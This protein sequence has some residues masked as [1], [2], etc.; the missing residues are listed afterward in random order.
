VSKLK[1][2]AAV[3]IVAC[4]ALAV[5]ACGS[6]SNSGGGGETG[7]SSN[8]ESGGGESTTASSGG[9][10]EG[11]GGGELPSTVKVGF[12]DSM[13]GPA[14]FCGQEEKEGAELAIEMA[15]EEGL[16]G[17][18]KIQM[19]VKDD[20]AE[21]ES[22]VSGMNSLIGDSSVAATV[23]PCVG[24]IGQAVVP[25]AEQGEMPLV[26]TTA[27]GASV[28]G[29]WAFRAGLP[30][31]TYAA[32]VIPVIAEQA[33]TAGVIWEKSDA[34][35]AKPVWEE[36]QKPALEEN[37]VELV[38]DEPTGEQTSYTSQ[39]SAILSKHP[40]AVGVLVLG[41]P[42]LTIVKELRE[43]GFKGPIWGQLGMAA[44]FYLEGGPDTNGTF[45]AVSYAP[46]FKFP[47]SVKFTKGFE[48]KFHKTPRE[49]SAHGYDAMGMTLKAIA[50]AGTTERAAVREALEGI[51]SYEGAQGPLTFTEEGDARGEGGVVEV[52][53]GELKTVS[54]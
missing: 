40:E 23:G 17:S 38:A 27:S 45:I 7:S 44:E 25:V 6:N 8:E 11:G 31:Q 28:S 48:A 47:G 52:N 3:L 30:Q 39:V 51:K 12:I 32:K 34:T 54:E 18:S 15:E 5:A 50:E 14:G 21:P 9:E 53:E 41:T 37:D 24:N 36:T 33:K 35:I 10:S 13:T 19:E 43:G 46:G 22:A 42:N 26:M 29:E 2:L 20:K 1:P 49:L 4:L 16:L